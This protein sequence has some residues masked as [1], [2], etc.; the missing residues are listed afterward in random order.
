MIHISLQKQRGIESDEEQ[1]GEGAADG[2]K[3]ET[4]PPAAVAKPAS[5]SDSSESE[6]SE[7][8]MVLFC[9]IP[10]AVAIY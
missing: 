8:V 1:E 3:E 5:G 7:E 6:S 9:I 10:H 2:T 4:A